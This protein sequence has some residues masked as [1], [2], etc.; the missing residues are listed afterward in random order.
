MLRC[1]GLLIQ[2]VLSTHIWMFLG[3][4]CYHA[5]TMAESLNK[6]I[7]PEIISTDPDV[8]KQQ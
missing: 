4:P 5:L 3:V 1:I 7:F 8:C 2:M 6:G